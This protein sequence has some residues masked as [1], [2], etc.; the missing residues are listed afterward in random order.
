MIGSGF[1]AEWFFERGRG[2]YETFRPQIMPDFS[3]IANLDYRKSLGVTL[4]TLTNLADQLKAQI[5]ER[6]SGVWVDVVA[7]DNPE[8]LERTLTERALRGLRFG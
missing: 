1:P 7:V 8:L 2:Y 3:Y 5:T 6:Y 4:L